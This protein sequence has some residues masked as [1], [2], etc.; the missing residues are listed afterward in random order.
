[1]E[2]S[3]LFVSPN[4]IY[5]ALYCSICT[6]VFENPSILC[7]GHTFCQQCIFDWTVKNLIKKSKPHC[8]LCNC[9]IKGIDKAKKTV[10]L[11]KD[12]LATNIINDLEVFCKYKESGCS[13]KGVM[14]DS[15]HHMKDLCRF[16]NGKEV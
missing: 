8:P 4:T 11:V 5:S 16:K 13:W 14:S 12:L 7:C 15:A 6:E 1:M 3:R 9:E 10:H 2:E